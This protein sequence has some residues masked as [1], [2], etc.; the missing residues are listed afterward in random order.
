MLPSSINQSP[1]RN[2]RQHLCLF[3]HSTINLVTG[4]ALCMPDFHA[5]DPSSLPRGNTFYLQ[6]I[7]G[8]LFPSNA[9]LGSIFARSGFLIIFNW[10]VFVFYRPINVSV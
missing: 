3:N 6:L 5:G 4:S 2:T 8:V 9:F 7:L 1:I 10:K